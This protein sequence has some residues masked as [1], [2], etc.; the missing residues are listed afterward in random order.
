MLLLLLLSYRPNLC[1]D[2]PEV[3]ATK[4]VA[5]SIPLPEPLEKNWQHSL[6]YAYGN[7]ILFVIDDV[8]IPSR[9]YWLEGDKIAP[10]EFPGGKL[11][12]H[13]LRDVI[14]TPFGI[15]AAVSFDGN[16]RRLCRFDGASL[17][18]VLDADGKVVE[19]RGFTLALST[20]LPLLSADYYPDEYKPPVKTLYRYVDG[21]LH[22]LHTPDG[23]LMKVHSWGYWD[24]VV[25]EFWIKETKQSAPRYFQAVEGRV[26]EDEPYKRPIPEALEG[27]VGRLSVTDQGGVNLITAPAKDYSGEWMWL[28]VKGEA[29]WITASDGRRLDY[30][31]LDVALIAGKRYAI[32]LSKDADGN[33]TQCLYRGTGKDWERIKLPDA[34]ELGKY[35]FEPSF[36]T[37][38]LREH[39]RL[40]P[41][42][43]WELE[44][45]EFKPILDI[46]GKQFQFEDGLSLTAESGYIIAGERYAPAG[47]VLVVN[48][49]AKPV[50]AEGKDK[51]MFSRGAMLEF[52]DGQPI[53]F[54]EEIAD[55]DSSQRYVRVVHDDGRLEAVRG[56][57]GALIDGNLKYE[58]C[59]GGNYYLI[60]SEA[61]VLRVVNRG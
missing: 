26:V 16:H 30:K 35:S 1:Q 51:L 57:D 50:Q 52:L 27:K 12:A 41:S 10:V 21:A 24:S 34:V 42:G 20:S 36:D 43:L 28:D 48:R 59:V 39:T 19:A 53:L 11:E 38:L 22:P 13:D 17:V 45:D 56:T 49:V 46:Q 15:V 25:K 18:D 54:W 29:V 7:G 6:T 31:Q 40:K 3:P 61:G 8:G 47:A 33:E 32:G 2:K 5:I 37:V 58:Y 23:E 60:Q 14:V 44:G 4:W 9:A 55:D